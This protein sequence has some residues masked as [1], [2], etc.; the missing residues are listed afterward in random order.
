[1]VVFSVSEI[2]GPTF[3][4][5]ASPLDLRSL[6]GDGS[7]ALLVMAI[8][9]FVGF[10]Q[11]VVF[12]EE[13]RDRKRAVPRATF[14]AIA[15]I[16][17]VYAFAS[18]AMISAAGK[19]VISRAKNEGPELFFNVGSARLG[20]SALGLGHL[21]FLTSLIAAMISFH[22]VVARYAFSLGREGVLPRAFGRTATSTGAPIIGSLAQ[23]AL[24]LTVIVVFGLAGW[25][26]LVQL[27]YWGAAAG[28]IGVMLLITA[29]SIAVIRYFGCHRHDEGRWPRIGAPVVSSALLV[30]VCCLAL[31][32]IATLFGVAPASMLTWAIP[33]V[34]AITA[35]AGASWALVL[36]A[37]RPQVYDAIG[38]GAEVPSVRMSRDRPQPAIQP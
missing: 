12:S 18:W 15:L 30:V 28:G 9:G 35:L 32:N 21:L 26:P 5:S 1:V 4:P 27:F 33:T 29:T 37:R 6:V 38:L 13:L 25:E 10:E 31:K 23:S 17:G 22:N 7:G 3:Y 8:T 14:L 2:S 11:T 36:R 34:F 20:A 16:A 19:D 24:G